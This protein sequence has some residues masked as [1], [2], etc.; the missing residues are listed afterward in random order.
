MTLPGEAS[1][2]VIEWA[3]PVYFSTY[4]AVITLPFV[5]DSR[6][7]L[8]QFQ[9]RALWSMLLVFPLFLWL[10]VVAP[11]RSFVPTGFCGEWLAL[12]RR[13]DTDANAFPSFHV[14]WAVIAA[15]TL[16]ER[17][18]RRRVL[19]WLW[20]LL[21]AA[22]CVAT[23]MHSVLD[24]L[25]GLAV[26][27]LVVR[28][29]VVW[30]SL[31]RAA[32]WLANSWRAARF[33]RVRIINHG[34]YA[35]IGT[36]AAV[37]LVEVLLGPALAVQVAVLAGFGLVFAGAWAQVIEGS[38][39]LSRPYGF[40]GGVLGLC[41]GA[42]VMHWLGSNGFSL[43]AC[44]RGVRTVGAVVWQTALPGSRLLPWRT[45]LAR[46]WN[47]LLSSDV[48]GMSADLVPSRATAPDTALLSAVER[49]RGVGHRETVVAP[50]L[51]ALHLWDVSDAHWR[52]PV[53]RRVVSRRTTDT[54][55]RGAPALSMDR[56]GHAADRC[57]LTTI[58]GPIWRGAP[59]FHARGFLLAALVGL[60]V[61]VALGVDVPGSKRRFSRLA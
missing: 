51:R 36:F 26:G 20:A 28:L 5:P 48:A 30:R 29:D 40:Y 8:R 54:G 31:Q 44:L 21:V 45:G 53:R 9:V 3:E 16:G 33:G 41:L 22:S 24:V 38:P 15:R 2:R 32:E 13:F 43:L 35:G 17:W 57:A 10:P 59:I 37:A 4:L 56:D 14:V 23:G 60:I 6:R 39:R 1:W 61:A 7:E 55:V 47:S 42:M 19:A 11:P 27:M 58:E 12:E 49:A 50:L 25:A 18:P 52:R 46:S 34:A